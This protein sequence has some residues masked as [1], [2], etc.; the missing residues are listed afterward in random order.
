M[1]Q[2][3]RLVGCQVSLPQLYRPLSDSVSKRPGTW[4]AEEVVVGSKE[5]RRRKFS[6][7]SQLFGGTNMIC[8][9]TLKHRAHDARSDQAAKLSVS[10]RFSLSQSPLNHLVYRPYHMTHIARILLEKGVDSG[11]REDD[12]CIPLHWDIATGLH[13]EASQYVHL[14]VVNF[15][16]I[17]VQMRMPWTASGWTS[18]PC[19]WL[20]TPNIRYTV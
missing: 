4:L 17:M 20:P 9:Q 5:E 1:P 2:V 18:I 12:N 10:A 7:S 15:P 8:K 16:L 13:H 11:A 6:L 3:V 14:N 19:N